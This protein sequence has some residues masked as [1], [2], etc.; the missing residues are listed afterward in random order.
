MNPG[1]KDMYSFLAFPK[2]T[3]SHAP[4]SDSSRMCQ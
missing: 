2:E 4:R 3:E 1:G